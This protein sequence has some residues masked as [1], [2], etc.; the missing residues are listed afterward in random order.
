MLTCRRASC[1]AVLVFVQ[2]LAATFVLVIDDRRGSTP[3]LL[4]DKG[5]PVFERDDSTYMHLT[6]P[7]LSNADLTCLDAKEQR[8][9]F[10]FHLPPK[11]ARTRSRRGRTVRAACTRARARRAVEGVRVYIADEG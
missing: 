3:V 9:V 5:R 2:T 11:Q 8:C 1:S 7:S 4:P 10:F 6:N